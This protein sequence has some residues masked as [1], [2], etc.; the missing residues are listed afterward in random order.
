MNLT[1]RNF[2]DSVYAYADKMVAL[3]TDQKEKQKLVNNVKIIKKIQ[4]QIE[5]MADIDDI[6]E[7]YNIAYNVMSTA[8]APELFMKPNSDDNSAYHAFRHVLRGITEYYK[9]SNRYGD[10]PDMILKPLKNWHYKKSSSVLKD[11]IYPFLPLSHF[12]SKAK[13]IAK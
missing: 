10:Y 3:Y 1:V 13:E 4:R 11:F 12:A 2:F 5:D 7:K 9:N 6:T 8:V